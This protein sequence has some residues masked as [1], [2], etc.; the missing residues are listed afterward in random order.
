MSSVLVVYGTTDG[1]TGKVADALATTLRGRGCLVDVVEAK[2]AVRVSPA[3]Y[4]AVIVAA[5]VH[6]GGYQKAV[7]RWV[8]RYR[9]ELRGRPSAFVS[10]CLGVLEKK[11]ATD[12]A[13]RRTL[14]AFEHATSW[15]PGELKIVA[16]ALPWTRYGWLKKRVMRRIVSKTGVAT[17]I[18]RDVEYTDWDDLRAFTLGFAERHGLARKPAMPDPALAGWT[19]QQSDY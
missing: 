8:R 2:P 7:K 3:P 9:P 19:H 14:Q 11:P 6:S 5:S 17:D 15:V 10:V 12:L 4:D 16:G 13:L 1:Q 18:S